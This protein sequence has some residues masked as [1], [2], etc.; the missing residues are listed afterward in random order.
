MGR[1]RPGP[2]DINQRSEAKWFRGPPLCS[3]AF[4]LGRI[5]GSSAFP[6]PGSPVSQGSAPGRQVL[7]WE[8]SV[9]WLLI[10]GP[11]EPLS[12]KYAQRRLVFW[13][14]NLKKE[15]LFSCWRESDSHAD[16]TGAV[17]VCHCS[18]QYEESPRSFCRNICFVRCRRTWT[19]TFAALC[20]CQAV[21]C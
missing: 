9:E 2:P 19:M 8:T 20:L 15:L 4:L 16:P 11:E 12:V 1:E 5:P 6:L 10:A 3:L 7:S 21:L 13:Q 18:F 17:W 14:E